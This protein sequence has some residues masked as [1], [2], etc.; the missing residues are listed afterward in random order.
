MS[1]EKKLKVR[2]WAA[3][4]GSDELEANRK[5]IEYNKLDPSDPK[6]ATVLNEYKNAASRADW[7]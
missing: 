1:K 7:D 6:R 5:A 3:C 4:L 2:P